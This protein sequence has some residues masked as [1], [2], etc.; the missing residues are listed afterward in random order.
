MFIDG[1]AK[2]HRASQSAFELRVVEY[3]V[4]LHEVDDLSLKYA[5]LRDSEHERDETTQRPARFHRGEAG[6]CKWQN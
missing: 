6:G 2:N 5:T 4:Q 3:T 1:A